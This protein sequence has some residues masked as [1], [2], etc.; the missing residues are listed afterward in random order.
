MSANSANR[1]LDILPSLK[2]G[3]S[4]FTE[5]SPGI[6]SAKFSA[7]YKDSRGRMQKCYNLP[8]REAELMV[9]EGSA[10]SGPKYPSK[11]KAA[12]V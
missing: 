10:R 12:S 6:Q 8:K 7:D 4:R 1:S 3:D 11:L 9:K 5:P 2:E